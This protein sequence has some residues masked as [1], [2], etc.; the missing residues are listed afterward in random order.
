MGARSGRFRMPDGQ[1]RQFTLACRNSMDSLATDRLLDGIRSWVEIETPTHAAPAIDQLMDHVA[2]QLSTL[3]LK[4]ETVPGRDGL[5]KH[6]RAAT[7]WGGDGP[8]ILVL[9]HLDTVHPIGTLGSTLP[10]RIEGDRAFGPGIYDMKGGAY[11]A[12]AAIRAL[13]EAGRQ[14]PLPIRWLFTSDE[15]I[16]SPTSR[17]LIER[18]GERARYVLVTEPAR[19]GGKCVTARKGTARYTIRFHGRPSHSGARHADGRSAV[20]ELCRQVLELE[21]LTDYVRGVT[22][23]V[24][25]VK[26]GTAFNVVPEHAEAW[27]DIRLPDA[28]TAAEILPKV[29]G[30]RPVDQDVRITVEGALNRPPYT[31][32]DATAALL[33]HAQNLANELGFELDETHSGGGSDGNFLADRLPVLDGIG[34]DGDGAHTQHEHLLISALEARA[35]LM[36]RLFET[37]R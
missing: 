27:V 18:E 26:G 37:L 28:E 31:R 10:F 29:T 14:T 4:T 1:L 30:M 34:V 5:G 20:R 8:G 11:L 23:N 7:P 9:S 3:G 19:D 17:A 25:V 32:T 22:V 35:R 15:E 13:V 24:G 36:M 33:R 12:F 2:G 6:V 21:Q 16:G